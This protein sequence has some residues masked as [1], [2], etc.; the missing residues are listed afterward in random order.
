MA[1]DR[2]QVPKFCTTEKRKFFLLVLYAAATFHL[3]C[4]FCFFAATASCKLTGWHSPHL[5]SLQEA[6]EEESNSRR[7][8]G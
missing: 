2:K 6:A 7:E 3:C 5:A 1:Y 8:G 4:Y